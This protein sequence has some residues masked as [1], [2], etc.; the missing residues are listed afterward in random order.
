LMRELQDV[1]ALYYQVES[2]TDKLDVKIGFKASASPAAN[3]KADQLR[4][5]LSLDPNATEFPVVFAVQPHSNAEVAMMSRGM[6]QIIIEY[7]ADIDAPQSDVEQGRVTPTVAAT[8]GGEEA[9]AS[10]LIWVHTGANP[11]DHA[12][13]AVFYREQWF[14]VDDRDLYSKTSM[15]FL[16]TLF[17]FTERGTTSSA[18]PVITVPTY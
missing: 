16:M 11:P 13:V 8:T 1:R 15:Q 9:V 4:K 12:H 7:A 14:W 10:R 17:S 5:L 2:A 18:T 3:A 6:E